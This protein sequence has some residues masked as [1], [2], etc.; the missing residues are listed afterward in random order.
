[1]DL[2]AFEITRCR[3]DQQT[4]PDGYSVYLRFSVTGPGG[5]HPV[6]AQVA[7]FS[8]TRP[9]VS[10]DR[11]LDIE[12]GATGYIN[13]TMEFDRN[14]KDTA[15]LNLFVANARLASYSVRPPGCTQAVRD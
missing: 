4:R 8:G 7:E 12:H 3:Q 1:L 5:I 2:P 14:P 15:T 9:G 10:H 6:R 13:V 11:V